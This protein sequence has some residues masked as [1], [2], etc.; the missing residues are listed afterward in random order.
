M[1]GKF[2]GSDQEQKLAVDPNMKEPL[3]VRLTVDN[4]IQNKA[5]RRIKYPCK[6]VEDCVTQVNGARWFLKVDIIKAFHQY[7]LAENRAI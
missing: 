1:G 7:K 6:T 3:D 2:S 4:R 5:I